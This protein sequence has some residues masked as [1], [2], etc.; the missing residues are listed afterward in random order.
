[1]TA[2][3]F[4]AKQKVPRPSEAE[5]A[6]WEIE[7]ETYRQQVNYPLKLLVIQRMRVIAPGGKERHPD[8]GAKPGRPRVP[9]R[10]F[11]CDPRRAVTG[12]GAGP[13]R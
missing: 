11:T 5:G 4:V 7:A 6:R 2:A 3:E 10:L 13:T 12:P 8:M 1:M 9:L